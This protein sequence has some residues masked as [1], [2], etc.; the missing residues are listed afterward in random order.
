[1]AATS[2]APSTP[3][4]NTTLPAAAPSAGV[5]AALMSPTLASFAGAPREAKAAAAAIRTAPV[6]HWVSAAPSPVSAR[7]WERSAAPSP[8]STA[9]DC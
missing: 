2:D 7:A 9:A 5:S 8:L 3:A 4:P 6:R 1:M